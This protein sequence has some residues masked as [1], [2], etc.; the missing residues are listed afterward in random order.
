M[1]FVDSSFESL[2]GCFLWYLCQ[3]TDCRISITSCVLITLAFKVV[4]RCISIWYFT[5]LKTQPHDGCLPH[6]I[7]KWRNYNVNLCPKGPG[8]ES[9]PTLSP[10]MPNFLCLLGHTC[11]MNNIHHFPGFRGIPRL[12]DTLSPPAPLGHLQL[13]NTLWVGISRSVHFLQPQLRQGQFL[14]V[15]LG[16]AEPQVSLSLHKGFPNWQW[17]LPV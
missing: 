9:C 2:G 10:S 11:L 17:I 13:I 15:L 5:G 1:P 4:S 12:L 14:I 16:R 8:R 3:V 7:W 6:T